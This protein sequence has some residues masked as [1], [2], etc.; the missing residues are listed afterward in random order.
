MLIAHEIIQFNSLLFAFARSLICTFGLVIVITNESYKFTVLND[1][2][3]Y[4]TCEPD[5]F[6]ST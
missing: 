3:F 1:F 4:K 5:P 6:D 2:L